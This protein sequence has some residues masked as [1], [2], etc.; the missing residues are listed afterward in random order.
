MQPSYKGKKKFSFEVLTKEEREEIHYAALSVL[1]EVGTVIKC[2][3]IIVMLEE[4]GAYIEGEKVKIPRGMVEKALRTVPSGFA[5]YDRLGQNKLL[6]EARNVYFG[7]GPSTTYTIDPYSGE[8]RLPGKKDTK[9]AARVMDALEN[10]DFV[11]D[12]GVIQDVPAQYADIHQLQAI[13]ENTSKPIV[14]WGFDAANLKIILRMCEAVAG[15][16]EELQKKPFMA[17]FSCSNSPLLHTVEAIDKL[18]FAAENLIP[19]IYVSA[20]SAGATAPVS[21]AGTLVLTLAECLTGLVIHQMVHEGAPFAIGCVTGATDM[22]TMAMSYGCPEFNLM[23]AAFAEIA[24]DYNLPLWGTA[25]CTDAKTVDS[26]AALEATASIMMSELSG[27]NL[28]HDV[29]YLEGGNCSSLAMLVLCDE[30]IGYVRRISKGIRVD[31]DSLA[32]EA[33]KRV[34]PMGEFVTDSHTCEHF[35]EEL[36]FPKLSDR[37]PYQKWA[38]DGSAEMSDKAMARARF[39]IENHKPEPLEAAVREKIDE[40]VKKACAKA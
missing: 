31:R 12:F 39:L 3:E 4:R 18:V 33:I 11:M 36:W 1:E 24:H 10:I 22:Q 7:P 6:F 14:H 2:P 9:N 23:H 40:I 13:L 8:R 37:H 35:K 32:L 5:L 21:L 25:G 26:Q 29:G 30:I 16:L 28:V 15:S 17:L 34:G 20:P 38:A 19:T 27:A